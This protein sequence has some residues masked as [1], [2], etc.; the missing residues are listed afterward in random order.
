MQ[1]CQFPCPLRKTVTTVTYTKK[2]YNLLIVIYS[3]VTFFGYNRL[4]SEPKR[5][6]HNKS[7]RLQ[8]S[9]L[10]E[11]GILLDKRKAAQGSR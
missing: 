5:L 7:T 3:D 2:T 1:N 8:L 9:R 11:G 4:Q 10:A 6:H